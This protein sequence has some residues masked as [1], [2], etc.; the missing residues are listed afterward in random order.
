M[1]WRRERPLDPPVAP[2][3]DEIS[4]LLDE[5]NHLSLL[6]IEAEEVDDDTAIDAYRHRIGEIDR[7]IDY[8]ASGQRDRDRKDEALSARYTD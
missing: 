2:H 1:F 7:E 6:I 4:A 8:I 5:Q 3:T